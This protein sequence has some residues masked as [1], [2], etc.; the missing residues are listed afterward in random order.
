MAWEWL[1]HVASRG[2]DAV[3]ARS[4]EPSEGRLDRSRL[5]GHE[6]RH[7]EVS[8]TVLWRTLIWSGLVYT[9]RMAQVVNISEAKAQ[10]SRLVEEV[11]RGGRV[12]IGKAGRPV[13][14]LV[15]YDARP[16]RRRLG[17]WRDQD[18]WIAEDFDAPLPA[19]V[20]A[21]FEGDD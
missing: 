21:A 1:L 4:Y 8:G 5:V 20:Q 15:A 18:V 17:G 12:V 6:S 16:D 7:H 11:Q 14:V 10:L 13:A 19:D 2:D 9:R 3:L